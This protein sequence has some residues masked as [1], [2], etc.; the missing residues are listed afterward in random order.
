M[1]RQTQ[2]DHGRLAE[3]RDLFGEAEEVI[4]QIEYFD[5]ELTVPAVN[6]LRY[7]GN[8]LLRYLANP[9]DI[10][11]LN[12]AAKHCRRSAYDAYE[13]TIVFLLLEFEKFKNDYRLVVISEV[14]PD[15]IS[16]LKHIEDARIFIGNVQGKSRGDHYLGCKKHFKT[17]SSNITKLNVSRDELNKLMKRT[18]SRFLM[19]V[20][21][22]FLATV[23]ATIGVL[24]YFCS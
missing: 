4:K 1:S 3:I 12:D 7:A 9:S 15:Y 20:T 16:I 18:R 23:S 8:H 6:Q 11:E 2:L 14:I 19:S 13:A 24:V 17:L 10:E 21:G 22:I 5:G